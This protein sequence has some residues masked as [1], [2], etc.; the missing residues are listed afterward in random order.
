MDY[1][2]LA[3]R[4]AAR[5]ERL[6]A[7]AKILDCTFMKG[8]HVVTWRENGELKARAG[9]TGR[10][11]SEL[12]KYHQRSCAGLVTESRSDRVF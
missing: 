9:M 2:T 11:A 10:G 7:A 8:E 12:V 4:R 5:A 6:A 3:E 1:P